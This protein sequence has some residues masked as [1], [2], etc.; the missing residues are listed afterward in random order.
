MGCK[1]D[2]EMKTLEDYAVEEVITEYFSQV[3]K[4]YRK[5]RET[6]KRFK[7]GHEA[8]G[9]IL[10]ELDELWDIIKKTKDATILPVKARKECIQ[11]GAM[12]LA[13]YLEVT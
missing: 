5:A 3:E 13:T 2:E 7:S 8:Y 11:L 4:E 12:I 6:F 9:V 1:G 10:E